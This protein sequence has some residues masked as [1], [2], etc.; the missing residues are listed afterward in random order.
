[1]HRNESWVDK[2]YLNICALSSLKVIC[3]DRRRKTRRKEEVRERREKGTDGGNRER[4]M[5]LRVGKVLTGGWGE[6][7]TSPPH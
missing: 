3:R 5:K 2:T 1:M 7:G 4:I 6:E